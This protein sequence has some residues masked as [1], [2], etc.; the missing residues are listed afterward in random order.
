VTAG[1]YETLAA[2]ISPEI[3][4]RYASG[5]LPLIRLVNT[6]MVLDDRLAVDLPGVKGFLLSK[7]L[8]FSQHIYAVLRE[9]FQ[10]LLPEDSQYAAC[11]HGFE[12]FLTL[13]HRDLVPDWPIP[14]VG[15]FV[16][17]CKNCAD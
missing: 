3:K 5:E 1:G 15:C 14:L 16:W 17:R 11:F 10:G 6:G 4:M 2:L 8:P 9:S 7:P 13:V 12:C